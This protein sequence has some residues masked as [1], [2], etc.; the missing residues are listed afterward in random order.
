MSSPDEFAEDELLTGAFTKRRLTSSNNSLR[1]QVLSKT[2]GVIRIR[3]RL[4]RAA[5]AS[6]LV[7]CYIA[8][9][10]TMAIFQPAGSNPAGVEGSMLVEKAPVVAPENTGKTPDQIADEAA[11]AEAAKLRRYE[12]L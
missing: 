4:K 2:T 12:L 5:I 9:M 3:R 10:A 8:G 11:A 6:S 7:A 1:D